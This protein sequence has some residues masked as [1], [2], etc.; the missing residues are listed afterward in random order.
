MNQTGVGGVKL[1]SIDFRQTGAN[2]CKAVP[3]QSLRK[4]KRHVNTGRRPREKSLRP[5]YQALRVPA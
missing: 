4:L 5:G 1:N 3:H 2:G